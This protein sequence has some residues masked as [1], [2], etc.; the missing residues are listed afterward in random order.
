MNQGTWEKSEAEAT[1]TMNADEAVYTAIKKHGARNCFTDADA[2]A[3][4]IDA[5]SA[6]NLYIRAKTQADRAE[7]VEI[8]RAAQQ[9]A[10]RLR[11]ELE[12]ERHRR[13]LLEGTNRSLLASLQ[14][15]RCTIA[16]LSEELDL[17]QNSHRPWWRKLLGLPVKANHRK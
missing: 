10:D 14:Y 12:Q 11:R 6:I 5:V 16:Y 2:R 9:I 15:E 8:A 13:A 7:V 4:A 3:A 17:L 1:A